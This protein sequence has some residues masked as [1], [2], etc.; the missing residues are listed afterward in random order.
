[1]DF[2]EALLEMKKGN[3][4]RRKRWGYHGSNI[5]IAIAQPYNTGKTIELMT[6]PYIYMYKEV[7]TLEG[8]KKLLFPTPLSCESLLSDDWEV[9]E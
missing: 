5:Y 2:S 1:M 8:A 3:K 9:V 4:V 7:V 6:E